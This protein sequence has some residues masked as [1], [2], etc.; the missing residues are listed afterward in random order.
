M[1][2]LPANYEYSKWVIN[3]AMDKIKPKFQYVTRE[4]DGIIEH[5][6]QVPKG[7]FN[8]T[9]ATESAYDNFVSKTKERSKSFNYTRADQ[10]KIK[11]SIILDLHQN[12]STLEALDKAYD[13]RDGYVV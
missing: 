6:Y 10:L 1:K 4:F 7:N 9:Y 5:K 8:I 11:S 3:S 13:I 12:N 2:G